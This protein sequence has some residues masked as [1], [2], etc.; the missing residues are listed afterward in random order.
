MS[1][2][3]P[4]P[5]NGASPKRGVSWLL[6]LA[7]ALLCAGAYLP[8]LDAGFLYDDD[9]MLTRNPVIQRGGRSFDAE[10]WRGLAELWLPREPRAEHLPGIP[11]TASTFWLEWRLWG[12]GSSESAPSERGIGAAGYHATNVALHALSA[13]A[14]WR[15]LLRLGV[16]GAWFAAALWGVHPVGVESVAWIA[17]RKNVLSMLFSML[18]LGAWLRWLEE[19]SRSARLRALGCF[20]LAMLSKPAVATLP[21]VMLGVGAWK[22]GRLRVEELRASAPFFAVALVLGLVTIHFQNQI[23]MAGEQIPIGNAFERLH[24]ASFALGFYVWKV[25]WPFDLIPIYPRWHETLPVVIQVLPGIASLVLLASAWRARAKWGRHVLLGFGSFALLLAPALGLVRMSWLRLT[26]VADHF[27]YV[28]MTALIALVVGGLASWAATR[29]VALRRGAAALGLAAIA[30][31]GSQTA[32]YA[33]VFENE[34]RF[35]KHTLE[36]NPDSWQ[37]HNQMGA[38]LHGEGRTRDALLHFERAAA[39]AP[40][41]AETHNNV[42]LSLMALGERERAMAALRRALEVGR[43]D[44]NVL[45]NYA[46]T[47]LENGRLEEAAIHYEQTLRL[48]PEDVQSRV[49]LGTVLYRLGRFAEA[50]GHFEEALQR[51]PENALAR[52][53]LEIA[54]GRLT[55]P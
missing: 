37:A 7:I 53:N 34:R 6:G 1:P 35:W 30:L 44:P 42:G 26:L 33:A 41:L 47:M 31:L 49:A 12:D 54:R 17:E 43:H 5:R 55:T 39:L 4:D 46:N 8:V 22:L 21:L 48:A 45:R 23:A 25:L 2:R 40:G 28:A 29:G 11:L 50:V 16:P 20:L 38:I 24:R 27:Q 9:Q 19:R 36:H 32:G 15:V 51:E 13:V 10:S 18:A 3:Q 52:R 14:V